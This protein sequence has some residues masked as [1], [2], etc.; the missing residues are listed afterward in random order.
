MQ[1]VADY[2]ARLWTRRETA[3][4]LVPLAVRYRDG[5]APEA[6]R[7]H[8]NV[9]RWVE[10]N[11]Q[12]AA[13][14]GWLVMDYGFERHSVVRLADGGLVDI[15]LSRGYLFLPHPGDQASFDAF[16]QGFNQ[17]FWPPP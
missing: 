16:A 17:V 3:T 14:R 8:A 9:D 4:R 15:T 11:A 7:C 6:S 13:A 1:T 12:D 2:L 10:E 5:S